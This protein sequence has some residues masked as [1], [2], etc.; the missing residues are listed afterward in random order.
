MLGSPD[1]TFY[2][3]NQPNILD[4]ILVNKNLAKATAAIRADPAAVHIVRFPGMTANG[5]YK[6]PSRSKDSATPPPTLLASPI[7]SPSLTQ[8]PPQL[9]S[10]ICWT[11]GETRQQSDFSACHRLT[12]PHLP[13]GWG[14]NALVEAVNVGRTLA[15]AQIS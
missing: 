11:V 1:S 4:Q 13:G 9:K 2:F 5:R 15:L 7:T 14:L 6:S 10:P 3:E 8:R 12:W